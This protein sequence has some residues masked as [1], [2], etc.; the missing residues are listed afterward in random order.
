MENNG[1]RSLCDGI[2]P[3]D[4][5]CSINLICFGVNNTFIL[6]VTHF[7]CLRNMYAVINGFTSVIDGIML[8]FVTSSPIIFYC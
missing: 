8:G 3:L 2:S 5:Q 6:P 4:A 7:R 1:D